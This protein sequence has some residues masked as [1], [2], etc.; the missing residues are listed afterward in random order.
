PCPDAPWI[1]TSPPKARARSRMPRSPSD[2]TLVTAAGGMP[3]PSSRTTRG[4]GDRGRARRRAD[5]DRLGRRGADGDRPGAVD[6]DLSNGHP[7]TAG[8]AQVTA[9]QATH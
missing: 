6:D 1:T 9:R 7:E 8:D 3:V 4:T 5:V 2:F